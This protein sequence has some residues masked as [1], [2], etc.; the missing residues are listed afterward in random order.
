MMMG[1]GGK[2]KMILGLPW[3]ELEMLIPNSKKVVKG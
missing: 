2:P 3:W 1:R